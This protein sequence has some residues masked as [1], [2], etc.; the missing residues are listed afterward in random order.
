[1]LILPPASLQPLNHSVKRVSVAFGQFVKRGVKLADIPNRAAVNLE[2]LRHAAISDKLIEL[3][4][5]HPHI[6]S[7]VRAPQTP[8]GAGR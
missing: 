3:G 6:G 8:T 4:W 7:R 1:M 2:R 5:G